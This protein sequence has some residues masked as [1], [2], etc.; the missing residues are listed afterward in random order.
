MDLGLSNRVAL[1]CGS[2]RGIGRAVA[3]TLAHEG[4]RLAV[5]GRTEE[6]ARR[7]AQELLATPFAADVSVPAQAEAMVHR[8][9]KEL[10]P[11]MPGNEPSS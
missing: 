10:S 7:A 6:S 8:V 3:K 11:P 5:N 9:A 4:A 1:V 2:T